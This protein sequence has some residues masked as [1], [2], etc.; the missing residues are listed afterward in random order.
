MVQWFGFQLHECSKFFAPRVTPP[1][2]PEPDVPRGGQGAKK[3]KRCTKML[4]IKKFFALRVTPP[5]HPEPDAS[6]TDRK[7]RFSKRSRMPKLSPEACKIEPKTS[8]NR[9][10]DPPKSSP[11]GAKRGPR[12][13]KNEKRTQ[14]QQRR[15]Y[16]LDYLCHF[17]GKCG[18]H[19]AKLASKIEPKSIKNRFKNLS[20]K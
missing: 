12:R 2:H 4:K 13:P 14:I 20:K 8:Q 9:A 16:P 7:S 17:G 11:N 15:G 6:R 18:Q 1:A 19:G 3:S 10:P 5:A